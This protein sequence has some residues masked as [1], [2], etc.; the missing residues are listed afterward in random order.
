M[1][2]I[3]VKIL[4]LFSNNFTAIL[5]TVLFGG[6]FISSLLDNVVVVT[7]FIPII[8][9]I[10]LLTSMD[11]TLWWALLFG[12]C[13]GGNI[14]IIGSTA[15]FIAIGKLEKDRNESISFLSWFKVGILVGVV[16]LTCAFL[17]FLFAPH[18]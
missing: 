9:S 5:S 17:F 13:F 16:T 11:G 15:N 18:F 6:A 12:A 4:M 8:K 3:P 7:A 2:N 14:T 1:D 10:N